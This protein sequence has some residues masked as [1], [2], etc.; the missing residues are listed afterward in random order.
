MSQETKSVLLRVPLDVKQ[1]IEKEAA[2]TLSSQNSV[3]LR[4][5]RARM[6]ESEQPEAAG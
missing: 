1:W 5:I 4:C 6:M 2:P 3:I